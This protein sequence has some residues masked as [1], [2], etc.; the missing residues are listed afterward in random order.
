[1]ADI[2]GNTAL[3]DAIASKHHSIFKL[4]YYCTAFSHPYTAGDLLCTAAR[5]NDLTVMKELLKH[6][7]DVDSKDSDGKTAVQVAMEDSNVDMVNLLVMNGADVTNFSHDDFF[8]SQTLSEML[9]KRE[10]G[11]RITV[12]DTTLNDEVF[13]MRNGGEKNVDGKKSNGV[14]FPRVSIYRGHPVTRRKTSC[15]EP[16][17]LIR[18]PHSLEELKS[19]AGTFSQCYQLLKHFKLSQIQRCL[20]G[21]MIIKIFYMQDSFSVGWLEIF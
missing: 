20:E 12:S 16:G 11:H 17:K 7:L 19:I 9:Q 8:P 3:W 18:L 10:V 13:L 5:R 2:N 15:T 21:H 1:M 14:N 4:L 6:E